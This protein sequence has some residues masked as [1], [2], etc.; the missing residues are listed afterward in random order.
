MKEVRGSSPAGKPDMKTLPQAS[1]VLRCMR[2]REPVNQPIG[3]DGQSATHCAR[4]APTLASRENRID[5]IRAAALAAQA[6]RA[7]ASLRLPNR[8]RHV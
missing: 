8:S 1:K 6:A 5:R 7:R 2:C 3:V 4:C